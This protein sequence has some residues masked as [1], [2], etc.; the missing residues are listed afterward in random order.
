M[1]S[2]QE[3]LSKGP[4]G[5]SQMLGPFTVNQLKV[6]K[7]MSNNKMRKV[8]AISDGSGSTELTLFEPAAFMDLPIGGQI[9]IRGQ[10]E[11]NEY[12]GRFSLQTG[13]CTIDGAAAPAPMQAPQGPPDGN[14]AQ[15]TYQAPPAASQAPKSPSLTADQLVE[16]QVIHFQ[17]LLNQ[18]A[19]AVVEHGGD[20]NSAVLA[21][22]QMTGSADGWWFGH[23]Y[24]GYQG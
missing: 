14:Y 1:I 5:K 22:A 24:P 13:K 19:P 8:Y 17:K 3:A 9:T 21:A 4:K 12:Q 15:T 6:A 11:V 2:I 10:I 18:L 7:P 20:V 16:H 23:K